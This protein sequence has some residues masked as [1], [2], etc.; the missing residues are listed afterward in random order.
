MS[1]NVCLLVS[2]PARKGLIAAVT[3]F[4]EK[5]NGYILEVDEHLN[6]PARGRWFMRVEIAGEG[7]D[8]SR[9]EFGPA[10]A[11]LA[12]QHGIDWRVAH[13]QKPNSSVIIVSEYGTRRV[14]LLRRWDTG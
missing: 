6:P 12:Q 9:E 8:L 11:P 14:D 10:F 7:F 1:Y 5:H 3:S 2:G 4:I 13:T